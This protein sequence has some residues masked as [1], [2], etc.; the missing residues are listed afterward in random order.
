MTYLAVLI[1]LAARNTYFKRKVFICCLYSEMLK[2]SNLNSKNRLYD[3]SSIWYHGDGTFRSYNKKAKIEAYVFCLDASGTANVEARYAHKY[4]GLTGI[5]CSI[6]SSPGVSFGALIGTA[7][8]ST[9]PKYA[10]FTY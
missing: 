3:S 9:S 5:N 10:S 2:Q 8:D 4:I 6:S 7:W 1:I